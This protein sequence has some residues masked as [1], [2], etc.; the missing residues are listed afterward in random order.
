VVN[1]HI[2]GDHELGELFYTTNIFMKIFI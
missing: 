2:L 1:K